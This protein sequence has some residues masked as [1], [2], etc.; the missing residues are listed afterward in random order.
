VVRLASLGSVYTIGVVAIIASAATP[1]KVWQKYGATSDTFTQ[2]RY[3][4]LREART[5][6]STTYVDRYG[7]ASSSGTEVDAGMFSACMEAKGWR[8]VDKPK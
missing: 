4:C 7:G 6:Y 8:L 1:E 5:P 3:Q 2:D